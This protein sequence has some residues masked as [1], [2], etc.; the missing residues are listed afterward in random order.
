MFRNPLVLAVF[1]MAAVLS[2]LAHG[3]TIDTFSF[4]E[5]VFRGM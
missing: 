2:I 4:S 1:A 3:E 5:C